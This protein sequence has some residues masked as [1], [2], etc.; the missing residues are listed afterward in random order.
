[1]NVDYSHQ[2]WNQ[3]HSNARQMT[4]PDYIIWLRTI[5]TTLPCPTCRL[6]MQRY[7]IAH[8][9]ELSENMFFWA[10][11]FHNNVNVRLGKPVFSYPNAL[12]QY[13]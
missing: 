13:N 11:D 7:L 6:H 4:K 10:W 2:V 9:P 8:P 3:I 1:M 5:S 12:A